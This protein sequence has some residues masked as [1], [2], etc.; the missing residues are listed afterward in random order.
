MVRVSTSI[1]GAANAVEAAA[2]VALFASFLCSLATLSAV[3][4]QISQVLLSAM[5]ADNIGT[6]NETRISHIKQI[7]KYEV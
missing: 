6:G 2:E 5:R 7:R 3:A 1:T 4:P